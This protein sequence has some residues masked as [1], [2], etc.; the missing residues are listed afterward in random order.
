[1]GPVEEGSGGEVGWHD[2]WLCCCLQ[3]AAPVGLSPLTAALFFPWDPFPPQAVVPIGL[4]PPSA[5]PLLTLAFPCEGVPTEP[6][7]FPFGF[8]GGGGGGDGVRHVNVRGKREIHDW[9]MGD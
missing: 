9:G 1:M 4:P 2:A 6:P 7:D 3:R 5:L 8:G